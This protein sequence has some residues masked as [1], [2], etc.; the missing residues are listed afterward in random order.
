M[1]KPLD[2]VGASAQ[3]WKILEYAVGAISKCNGH[4][5]RQHERFSI[6]FLAADGLDAS[7]WGKTHTVELEEEVWLWVVF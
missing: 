4:Q 1:P 2:G 3:S 7:E 5:L 6:L